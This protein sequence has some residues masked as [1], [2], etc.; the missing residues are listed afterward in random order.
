MELRLH[1]IVIWLVCESASE[2]AAR[3]TLSIEWP[4][5]EVNCLLVLCLPAVKL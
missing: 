1:Q 4:T 2:E 5:G 3:K